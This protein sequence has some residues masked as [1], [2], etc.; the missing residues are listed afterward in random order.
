MAAANAACLF[1]GQTGAPYTAITLGGHSNKR[2]GRLES[3]QAQSLISVVGAITIAARNRLEAKE[4]Q[5]ADGGVSH[6]CHHARGIPG[7][8]LRTVFVVGDV[9]HVV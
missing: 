9:A 7:T 4:P 6:A 2:Q 3:E 5:Q 1:A 8:Y